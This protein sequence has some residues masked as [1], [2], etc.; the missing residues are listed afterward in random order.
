M[1]C[2]ILGGNWAEC[3]PPL[4]EKSIQ[5]WLLLKALFGNPRPK[6]RVGS[7]CRVQATDGN[8]NGADDVIDGEGRRKEDEGR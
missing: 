4:V 5:T 3:V 1:L 7:H 6:R 8:N 2:G